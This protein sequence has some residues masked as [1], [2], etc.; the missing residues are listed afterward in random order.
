MCCLIALERHRLLVA[1]KF[2]E[3]QALSNT[4]LGSRAN[5]TTKKYLYAFQRWTIES[6]HFALYLQHV[7]MTRM[8][9]KAAEEEAVNA[10][11]LGC[12]GHY[13]GTDY[14]RYGGKACRGNWRIE[15][16]I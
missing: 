13:A 5:T 14:T 1:V 4:V 15:A 9:S 10:G 2:I 8:N 16:Q 7:G 3:G 12:S 6:H 11:E